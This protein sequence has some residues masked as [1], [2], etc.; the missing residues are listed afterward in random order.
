[1]NMG[2][3]QHR[4]YIPMLLDLVCT[5]VLDPTQFLTQTES[6]ASAIEAY[7]AFDTRAPGWLKVKLAT[8]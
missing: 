7:K 4:K 5:G 2:N 8:P 3:C 6:L 1:M